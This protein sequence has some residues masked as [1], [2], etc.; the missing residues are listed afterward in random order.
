MSKFFLVN[1]S[2][3]PISAEDIQEIEKNK[4]ELLFNHDN[5]IA[6]AT[7]ASVQKEESLVHISGRVV[8]KVDL[9]KKNSHVFEDGTKI[10]LERKFNEF[11]R[12]ITEPTNALVISAE[13]IP[14][15][16]EILI[17]HNAL[18][19]VNRI[20]DYVPLS[21]ENEASEVKY[22]SLPEDDCYAWRNEN[23]E[24]MPMKNYAFALRVYT[25]YT[26][27][28][29]GIEHSIIK[30]VL[31]ITTGELKNNICHVLKASDYE[32]IYQGESGREE[33]VIRCRHF[34]DDYNDKEEVIAI[35]NDL[36]DKLNNGYLLVGLTAKYAKNI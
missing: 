11:N 36:T 9:Q 12:R 22:Y 2:G 17:G 21:G 31:Y 13:N 26:G 15:G 19:E 20:Y 32:I 10:R 33:R 5:K 27:S 4:N 35:A 16:S 1:P 25:P 30:D 28:L 7:Q 6:E 34:E 18:H 3:N 23:G 29:T 14:S 24:L 8:I